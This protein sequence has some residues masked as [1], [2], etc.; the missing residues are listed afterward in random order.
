MQRRVS[1]YNMEKRT[2]KKW[3]GGRIFK[4]LRTLFI[5]QLQDGMP[6]QNN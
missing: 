4:Y 6:F 1:E 2:L 3:Q 5:L